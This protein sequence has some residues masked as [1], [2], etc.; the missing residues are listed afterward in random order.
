MLVGVVDK[1]STGPLHDRYWICFD[2]ESDKRLGITLN[3]LIGMGKKESAIL[4]ID[5]PT[6]LYALH[7]YSRYAGRKIKRVEE[8]ELEYED[9]TLE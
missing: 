3:S 9:F 7:S 8:K 6:A 5:N 1:L 4:P 2:E